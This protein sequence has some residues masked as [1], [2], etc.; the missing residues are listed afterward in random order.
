MLKNFIV[1]TMFFG[2]S[3]S[4]IVG[5][6]FATEGLEEE[7][8]QTQQERKSVQ[9]ELSDAEVSLIALVQELDELNSQ[10]SELDDAIEHN[11][12]MIVE[13]EEDIV[14]NEIEVE[15]LAFDMER[16]QDDIDQRF[17]LLKD[18]ASSY[19]KNGGASSSYIEVVLGSESFGDFVTR[20][21]TISRIAQADNDFIEQLEIN[22]KELEIVQEQHEK[23]LLELDDQVI[24]LEDFHAEIEAQRVVTNL[25]RDDV[26]ENEANQKNLITQLIEEDHDLALK[27]E[28]IRDRIKDE[29]QRQEAEETLRVEKEDQ[30]EAEEAAAIQ[31]EKQAQAKAEETATKQAAKETNAEAEKRSQ[32]E[33]ASQS[34]QNNSNSTNSNSNLNNSK[35]KSNESNS[36]SASSPSNSGSLSSRGTTDSG[37]SRSSTSEKQS[38][39]TFSATAYT[40]LCTGCSGI[41]STGIN[42]NTNPNSKV[43]A[44]D[45][46][47][48]PL[49]S[50]VE[51]KGYGTFLAADTGGAING[52]K[53]D[54]FMAKRGDA[55]SFGRRNVEIR[56]LD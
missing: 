23:I 54:I 3:Q 15:E 29:I 39:K 14:E 31:R 45:P 43:I 30:A 6:V 26:K 17:E 13:T 10:L 35:S 51:V 47:V 49:G 24:E 40:A 21:V 27:E 4:L 12:E 38:W 20:V 7:Q 22:Q 44:V 55:V 25:L 9:S 32:E 53:I 1:I 46:S 36:S 16:L 48:I 2:L 28:D 8:E 5:S 52:N 19:Q 34:S 37:N 42:L 11:E 41:T 56:V 18:R 50:R 33:A